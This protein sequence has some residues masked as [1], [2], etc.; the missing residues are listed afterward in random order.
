[1]ASV[2]WVVSVGSGGG[3][4]SRPVC[5]GMLLFCKRPG[6]VSGG[7][8]GAARRAF[9]AVI[10]WRVLLYNTQGGHLGWYEVTGM[11]CGVDQQEKAVIIAGR[12]GLAMG[13]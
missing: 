4:S 2:A 11:R 8:G 13:S 12:F 7:A 3:S 6:S 1:M 9:S 10:S 5:L